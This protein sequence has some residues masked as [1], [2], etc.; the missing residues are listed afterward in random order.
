MLKAI[1]FDLDGTIIDTETAWYVAL[2][3]LYQEH[4]VEL[5][6]EL[7][8]T[9]IGTDLTAFNPYEYLITELHVQVDPDEFKNKVRQR[10]DHLMTKEQIRPGVRDYLEQAR[11]A[12]IKLA[13]ASSSNREWVER[14][15]QQ[16][17]VL[18]YFDVIRTADDVRKVKPDPELYQQAIAALGVE[19]QEAIAVEDSPNGA[20]AAAAA[21]LHCLV[22]PNTITSTLQFDLPHQRVTSLTD[23]AFG[24]LLSNPFTNTHH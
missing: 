12:G 20:R 19:P 5:S 18:D 3:E 24:E 4:G 22:V 17:G 10:Y 11:A 23:L 7:Y 21:G 14:H 1:I 6:L 15:L 13:V 9:C 8:S 16:L 2:N